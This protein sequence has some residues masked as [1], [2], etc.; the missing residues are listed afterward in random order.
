[1]QQ[2]ETFEL[3]QQ[4]DDTISPRH[5]QCDSIIRDSTFHIESPHYPA[6]Y[7]VNRICTYYIARNR[8]DV[9]QV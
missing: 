3:Q 9:C 5:Y 2:P 7:P 6:T 4:I 1:M 8:N